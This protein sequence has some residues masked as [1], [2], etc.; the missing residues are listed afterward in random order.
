M[1][2]A[3]LTDGELLARYRSGEMD[4]FDHLVDRYQG[5]LLNFA[6]STLA[7]PSAAEDV[8]QEV[9]YRVPE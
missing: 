4:A 6:R 9:Q 8:V 5:R 2:E 7:D 1:A 3:E